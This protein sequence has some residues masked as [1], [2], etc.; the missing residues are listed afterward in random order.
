MVSVEEIF[1]M[2]DTKK[3][4]LTFDDV[5]DLVGN[6]GPFQKRFNIVFNFFLVMCATMPYFNLVIALSIPDHWCNVP[7]R[8]STNYTIDEWKTLTIPKESSNGQYSF[9]KCAMFNISGVLDLNET[10]P[11]QMTNNSQVIDCQYGWEYNRTWYKKTVVTQEDWVCQKELYVTNIF[12][13]CRIGELVGSFVVGQLGDT[14][15][16]KPVFLITLLAL[17][18]GKFAS[19]FTA[20]IFPLFVAAAVIGSLTAT[21]VYSSPL[22]IAM[23]MSKDA[24]RSHIAMLQCLSWTIGLA[25]MPFIMW[26]IGDWVY[27]MILTTLPCTLFLFLYGYMIESPRWLISKGKTAR[28]IKELEKIAKANNTRLPED[29]ILSLAD[30]AKDTEKVYGVMSLFSHWR[31]AKNTICV[32]MC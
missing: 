19:I 29:A 20:H 28:C 7:G 31:L 25:A 4:D 14:I 16:R 3:A 13:L 17:S 23:E 32:V 12:A 30:L 1:K 24:D 11:T 27:F 26:A 10:F 22:I 5:L 9:S 21:A 18:V 2:K 8:E 6:D 15:G